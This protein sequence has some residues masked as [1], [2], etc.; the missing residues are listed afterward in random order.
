MYTH[1]N[2][3]VVFVKVLCLSASFYLGQNS[4][5]VYIL[6]L[7]YH[8][9]SIST[10]ALSSLPLKTSVHPVIPPMQHSHWGIVLFTFENRC[11]SCYTTHATYAACK[12]NLPVAIQQYLIG[13]CAKIEQ[14]LKLLKK[15]CRYKCN[16]LFLRHKISLDGLTYL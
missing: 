5:L 12:R 11:T 15:R 1:R 3:G 16:S 10:V 6:F 4:H 14:T 2:D 8:P 9:C 13:L 7:L